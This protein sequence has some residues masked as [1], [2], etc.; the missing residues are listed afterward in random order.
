MTLAR[1]WPLKLVLDSVIL[2]KYTITEALPLAPPAFEAWSRHE[3]L[4]ALCAALVGIALLE[5][6][7]GY[8]QKILFAAVGQSATTDVLEH[9]FTHIQTLPR[10]GTEG[11]RTG[12]LIVR[13]TSDIK[14][15]R[16]LLVNHVQ[17]LG[18]YGLTFLS[19]AVVMALMNWQLTSI[20]LAVVP[21]IFLSSYRFSFRIRQATKVKRKKEGEVA[22]IVQETVDALAVVQ[23]FAQEEEERK[24]F[25]KEARESLD[26]GLES[27][28]LGGAFSRSVKALNTIGTALVI[29]F[30]GLR[31]LDGNLSPGDLVVF[32]AY[33][34]ELFIPIQNVSELA[35]QFMESLV[36][37]ERVLELVQTAPRIKDTPHAPNAPAFRG[38]VAFENVT[39]GYRKDA[40]VLKGLTFRIEPGKTIALVGG[41]GAG[42]SSIVSLLLRF[43][44]PWEGRILIDGYDIRRYKLKSIR[45]QISVVLQQSILFRRS[46]REN[47]AY[48]RPKATMEEVVAA[49]QSAHADEFISRMAE[50]YNTM[51]DE[52]G[53]NLSGGQRQRIAL[54]RAFLRNAPVL[55]LDEPTSGLDP[56]TEAQL[57][58]TLGELS[59]G[60]T[61][62]I[63]AHRLSTIEGADQILVLKG[64][65]IVQ[66]GTHA[67]LMA[68]EGLYRE[69]YEVQ[70]GQ[71]EGDKPEVSA[72]R[73]P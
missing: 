11:A 36:S 16:D 70:R 58:E 72:G 60:R 41:S 6:L 56:V 46:V 43:H 37:G 15:M 21:F 32:A 29:F 13:L 25:R 44:D 12:D 14:T 9:T 33:A 27:A 71:E 40:P 57:S 73:E 3:L 59:H 35:V 18:T 26:A 62:I 34:A 52:Q 38:E 69:M 31:V 10:W 23:A 66:Q 4:A 48:G 8:F 53:S 61:T 47:I 54:A 45:R 63:I 65:V 68:E 39:F 17:K 30:G 50:G 49:A 24:R 55:I 5:A 1:P 2:R 42:K 28:R 19:T 22:S 20:A 51:L 7:F 67:E 64:G